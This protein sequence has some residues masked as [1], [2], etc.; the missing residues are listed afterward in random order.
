MHMT[1]QDRIEVARVAWERAADAAK[2]LRRKL[3]Y[4]ERMADKLNG[5][6]RAH[7]HGDVT[8]IGAQYAAMVELEQ[9]RW[10]HFKT[11]ADI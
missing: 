4:V 9:Q 6:A 2:S 8:L 10:A 1:D 5:V 7:A 3:R 11:L